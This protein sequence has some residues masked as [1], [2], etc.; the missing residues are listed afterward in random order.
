MTKQ[1][2]SKKIKTPFNSTVEFKKFIASSVSLDELLSFQ[3]KFNGHVDEEV[4]RK[5]EE[6]AQLEEQRKQSSAMLEQA[7][8]RGLDLNV[9]KQ[10]IE[11]SV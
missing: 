3:A 11:E 10:L 9:L 5:A 2:R 7:K 6:E 8:A 1:T 4:R